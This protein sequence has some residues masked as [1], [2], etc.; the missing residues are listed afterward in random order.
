MQV[1]ASSQAPSTELY[2]L[3]T[4]FIGSSVVFHSGAWIWPLD[5]AVHA[6]LEQPFGSVFKAFVYAMSIAFGALGLSYSMGNDSSAVRVFLFQGLVLLASAGVG[7][8]LF[9]GGQALVSYFGITFGVLAAVRI[10]GPARALDTCIGAL[11]G[12]LLLS[13]LLAL[14]VP[15]LGQHQ[16]LFAGQWRG[17]FAHKN[18]LGQISFVSLGMA[19][20]YLLLRRGRKA[21]FLIALSLICLL[22]SGS[23]TSI[24]VAAISALLGA[25]VLFAVRARLAHRNAVGLV[26]ILA[27][28]GVGLQSFVLDYVLTLLGKDAS[29]SGRDE[30]WSHMWSIGMENPVLGHGPYYLTI[31]AQLIDWL[32][33]TLNFP[34]L[35]SPHNSYILTLIELGFLGILSFILPYL[36]IAQ[37]W[38][39]NPR[40]TSAVGI[41]AVTLVFPT[42][43]YNVFEATNRTYLGLGTMI[44]N[45]V[46]ISAFARQHESAQRRLLKPGL[47]IKDSRTRAAAAA[48]QAT[49]TPM[50]G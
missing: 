21:S 33:F 7:G 47:E 38:I 28:L 44:I 32:R 34:E 45:F 6:E 13:A 9:Y 42:A 22:M 35:R 15:S 14:A 2:W 46:L 49:P 26:I 37:L 12:I 31:D 41:L 39:K 40:F 4:I 27:L 48:K 36:L 43:V 24:S 18:Q 25:A 30:I 19:W 3:A 16:S 11:I 10:L 1:K 17:T 50:D 29:F 8:D 20:S 5:A 23:G